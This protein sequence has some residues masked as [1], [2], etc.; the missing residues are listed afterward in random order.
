M[1]EVKNHSVKYQKPLGQILLLLSALF[2]KMFLHYVVIAYCMVSV[3]FLVTTLCYG[4]RGGAVEIF[5]EWS[6]YVYYMIDYACGR[7]IS[8][9]TTVKY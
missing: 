8:V 7:G 2:A 4:L 9:K 6:S 5:E 1:E 3:L